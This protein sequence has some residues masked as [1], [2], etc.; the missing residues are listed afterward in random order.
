MKAVPRFCS[1]TVAHESPECVRA[2]RIRS[3]I[4]GQAASE[5]SRQSSA[6]SRIWRPSIAIRSVYGRGF[7]LVKEGVRPLNARI[8]VSPP[9]VDSAT[10]VGRRS[11]TLPR[12]DQLEGLPR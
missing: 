4:G 10:S 7:S 8:G 9:P 5:R 3:A 12:G 1:A 11:A 6:A 2:V